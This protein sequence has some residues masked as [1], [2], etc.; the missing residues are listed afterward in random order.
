M[1]AQ[2]QTPPHGEFGAEVAAGDF[3]AAALIFAG[4]IYRCGVLF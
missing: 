4:P 2:A 1:M 3:F